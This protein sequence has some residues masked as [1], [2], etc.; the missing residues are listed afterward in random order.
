MNQD[1]RSE[2]AEATVKRLSTASGA[3][4]ANLGD[5]GCVPMPKGR[6]FQFWMAVVFTG[7]SFVFIL[8]SLATFPL[9][10]AGMLSRETAM[11]LLFLLLILSLVTRMPQARILRAYLASRPDSL[12]RA[13]GMLPRKALGLEEGRTYKKTKFVIED[14]GVCLF[15]AERRRLLFEGCQ[16][17]YVLYAKDIL[18]VE[19]VAAYAL[20]GARLNCRMS[21][22]YLDFVLTVAGQGP[23]ASLIQAF[24]PS[25]GAK[26]LASELNRT[27][28]G[29]DTP[30]YHQTS[31]PPPLPTS[32][33]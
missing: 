6:R 22:H 8:S 2:A 23:L 33:R 21:G 13:F 12:L 25:E 1:F 29:Q 7:V 9:S 14:T 17:R 20:S 15:D 16:Y 4:L 27:L 5:S 31:L 32:V 3:A 30:S 28:F 19:P 10:S 18:S 11:L 26:G 24:V